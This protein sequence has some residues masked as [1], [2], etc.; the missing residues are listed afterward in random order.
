MQRQIPGRERLKTYPVCRWHSAMI[1]VGNAGDD[2]AD[3]LPDDFLV[4]SALL[5][6]EAEYITGGETDRRGPGPDG[7][8]GAR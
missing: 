2:L 4:T 8:P 5:I 6:A 1:D 3:H 7:D